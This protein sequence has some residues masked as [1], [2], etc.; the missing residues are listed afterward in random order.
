MYAHNK[1]VV[2]FFVQFIRCSSY[3]PDTYQTL[4][5]LITE[6]VK[7]PPQLIVSCFGGAQYFTMSDDL[8]KVFI[9]AIGEIA[10]TKS[11][12]IR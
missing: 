12:I 3:W 10:A 9:N 6:D 1:F 11:M 7:E 2:S 4:K 8:E 5:D